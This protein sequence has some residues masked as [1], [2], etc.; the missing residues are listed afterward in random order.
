LIAGVTLPIGQWTK[1][2][3]LIPDVEEAIKALKK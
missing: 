3:E 2:K 1:L